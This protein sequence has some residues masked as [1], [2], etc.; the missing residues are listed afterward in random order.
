MRYKLLSSVC[1]ALMLVSYAPSL[2]AKPLPPTVQ[3]G[4]AVAR[5]Y[6]KGDPATSFG[7]YC[8]K[9]GLQANLCIFG[10]SAKTWDT[11]L[12]RAGYSMKDTLESISQ[13]GQLGMLEYDA[14]GMG[15]ILMPFL[16]LTDTPGG[17]DFL[18]AKGM[19]NEKDVTGFMALTGKT[20]GKPTGATRSGSAAPSGS[21]DILNYSCGNKSIKL[22]ATSKAAFINK[23]KA[24]DMETRRTTTGY[25]IDFR[26][27]AE[28]GG[29]YTQYQLA[30]INDK[31]TL[32]SH[33]LNADGDPLR[34]ADVVQ[35]KRLEDT[36]GKLPSTKSV[37]EM[38]RAGELE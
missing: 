15:D 27:Y 14:I 28:M 11:A 34:A 35:C 33:W 1:A 30:G 13:R 19:L 29:T 31:I 8:R 32:T 10:A 23:D 16:A 4:K 20:A 3:A 24:D 17:M 21:E 37:M 5:N 2:Y 22:Y 25:L 12:S 26:M 38:I 7:A 6:P 18:V 9:E 36:K